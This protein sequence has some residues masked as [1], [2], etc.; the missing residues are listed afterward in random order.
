[1]PKIA[2]LHTLLK[3]PFTMADEEHTA[4]F[5]AERLRNNDPNNAKFYFE[6][7]LW[8]AMGQWT[9]GECRDVVDAAKGNTSIRTLELE[10]CPLSEQAVDVFSFIAGNLD[11]VV[12]VMVC[13]Y[14]EVGEGEGSNPP[15]V[16][17][18]LLTGITKSRSDV[19]FLKLFQCNSPRA[20][21]E[22][23]ERFPRLEALD[24]AG[25]CPEFDER[26]GSS[27]VD[28]FALSIAAAIGRLTM[29]RTVRF[30]WRVAHPCIPALFSALHT[31]SSVREV[32]VC[33]PDSAD[34]VLNASHYCAVTKT[35]QSFVCRGQVV[36]RDG[37]VDLSSFFDIDPLP[38]FSPTIKEVQLF[39][40]R[41]DDGDPDALIERAAKALKHVEFL[42]L[43]M[44]DFPA[45]MKLLA[46]LPLLKTVS[47][48]CRRRVLA[49]S[50]PAGS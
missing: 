16:I 40:F 27:S 9:A 14:L 26:T 46:R 20:F 44:C 34:V 41:F 39:M 25:P 5:F 4:A 50:I 15:S 42:R 45:A 47:C 28:A 35:T 32:D 18:R 7:S 1:M 6:R 36:S 19:R 8:E 12:N 2:L 23:A 48:L 24:I 31:S 22:F 49:V 10:L 38:S 43:S 17:D 37:F 29:L 11:H 21:F 33:I 3:D 13:D 30:D